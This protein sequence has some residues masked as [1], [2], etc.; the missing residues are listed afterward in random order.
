[1]PCGQKKTKE[2]SFILSLKPSGLAFISLKYMPTHPGLVGWGIILFYN[3]NMPSACLLCVF[4]VIISSLL[5][6]FLI[7]TPIIKH[8]PILDILFTYIYPLN[9]HYFIFSGCLFGMFFVL[10]V[11]NK[12]EV[13]TEK[14]RTKHGGVIS[15]RIVLGKLWFCVM[16]VFCRFSKTL[17]K[18]H[19]RIKNVWNVIFI[20]WN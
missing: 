5:D 10:H 3:H 11:R 18:I 1:M 14:T 2:W 20:F 13:N 9:R 15:I 7:A 16:G 8:L 4:L 12:H 6:S 19:F 17:Q